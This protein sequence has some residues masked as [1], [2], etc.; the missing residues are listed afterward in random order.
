MDLKEYLDKRSTEDPEFKKEYDDLEPEYRMVL[1]LI[2]LRKKKK[3]SQY[4]LAELL[5]TKQPSIARLES[6]DYN[7]SF[8][9]LKKIAKVLDAELDVT[10][11][12]KT[13]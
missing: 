4:K 5:D 11:K 7:P 12:P 3:I 9:F 1:Q 8:K 13:S 2:R 6:G 10:F